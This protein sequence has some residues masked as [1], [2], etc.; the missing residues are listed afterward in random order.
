ML[1][2][3]CGVQHHCFTTG[4]LQL[5][6]MIGEVLYLGVEMVQHRFHIAYADVVLEGMAKQGL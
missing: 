6:A 5:E 1:H 4:E 2:A 3:G